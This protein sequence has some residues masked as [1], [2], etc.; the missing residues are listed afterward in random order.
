MT[1]RTRRVRILSLILLAFVVVVSAAAR[2][3]ADP[4]A[5]AAD[6]HVAVVLGNGPKATDEPTPLQTARCLKA[7]DLYKSGAVNKLVVTGGF[8]FD[9]IS[10]ARMMKIALVTWGVTP[11][12]VIEDEMAA[13]TIE[14]GLFSAR[15]FD[16]RAWPKTA[17]LVTQKFH[18]ERSVGIY[19]ADGFQVQEAVSRD[20]AAWPEDFAQVPDLKPETLPK[21]EP[22]DMLVVYEPFS[23]PSPMPW[24]TAALAHRLRVAAALYHAVAAPTIVLY[25]DPYT[26]G[27]YTPAQMMKVA[28]VSLGVPPASLKAIGRREYRRLVDLAAGLRDT[29][30]T[31]VAPGTAKAL[32]AQEATAEWKTIFVD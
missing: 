26:R 22:S 28:L 8:T 27:P 14:N 24:P 3:A 18:M 10:E 25:N 30:V 17:R 20:A 2:L 23:S 32:L 13:S 9:Y 1:T 31:V 21:A 29:S 6:I 19:K 7:L 4:Q 11:D 5:P 15:I 12:D 16:E